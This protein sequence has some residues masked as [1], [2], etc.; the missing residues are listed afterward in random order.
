MTLTAPYTLVADIGGT[1]ARF[2]RV[3]AL[4]I[5]DEYVLKV[6]DYQ[7]PVDA[8]RAYLA[9]VTASGLPKRATF[10]LAGPVTGDDFFELTNH[11]WRFSI[12]ES[13]AALGLEQFDLINDFHAMALGILKVAPASVQAIGDGKAIEHGNIGVIGPGTGLG[14]ASLIWDARG[15]YYV[16]VP[17]EGPHVTVPIKTDREWAIVKWLLDNKYSHVS[18]ERVCSGKG[19]VNLYDTICAIDNKTPEADI[20]AETISTRALANSCA[21]CVEAVDLMLGFLGRV[22]GNLALV[23]NT[24]GGVYFCGGILPKLG[25]DAVLK[26]RLRDEFI[27]KGRMT[28]FINAMPTFLVDEPFLALKGLRVHA[29]G[30]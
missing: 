16:P 13:R 26:S 24:R 2:A 6:A 4:G 8:A 7:G 9:R 28:D 3:D 19:L 1:N 12:N 17:S 5:H 22:A 14:V 21:T 11:P 29:L 25:L 23:S 27:A 20:E 15:G 18:A 30:A 10:A